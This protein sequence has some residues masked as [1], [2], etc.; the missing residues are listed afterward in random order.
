MECLPAPSRLPPCLILVASS[1]TTTFC[2][3]CRFSK[4]GSCVRLERPLF[5]VFENED[6]VVEEYLPRT[7]QT[8]ATP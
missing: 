5:A 7:S 4:F 3:N 6:I 8:R 2:L 1:A